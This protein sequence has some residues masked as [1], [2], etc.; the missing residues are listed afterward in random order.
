MAFADRSPIIMQ[1]KVFIQERDFNGAATSGLEWVGN[2]ENASLSFK[3]KRETIKDNFTGKGLTLASPVVETDLEFM[4]SM[5]DITMNNFARA[6]WGTWTGVETS[7]AVSGESIVMYNDRYVQLA[8]TGVSNVVVAGAVLDTDYTVD[9]ASGGRLKVLST[10]PAAPDGTPLTTTVAYDY[11][12]NNG[13]V[14]AFVTAQ[15][16]YSI[17]VDGINVAQGNQPYILRIHQIQ[18]DAFKKADFIDK[19]TLKLESGGEILIDSTIPDDGDLS[20]VFF[21]RK[22]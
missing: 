7:G 9:S 16:F 8:K 3:Q 22:A 11:L 15:K 4:L 20:Q 18:L 10:S 12:A 6:S 13:Q 14:E 17:V 5:I 2:A 21:L 19:K 1:G